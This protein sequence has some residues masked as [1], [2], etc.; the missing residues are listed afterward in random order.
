MSG[1][2]FLLLRRRAARAQAKT[3][4]RMPT[5]LWIAAMLVMTFRIPRPRAAMSGFSIKDASAQRACRHERKK[6]QQSSE[7]R[8]LH[9]RRMRK[10]EASR[11]WLTA[12]PRWAKET[13]HP[14]RNRSP[15]HLSDLQARHRPIVGEE[16]CPS[17]TIRQH[18]QIKKKPIFRKANW[19]PI[20]HA[21]VS[22]TPRSRESDA[23]RRNALG[24]FFPL[25]E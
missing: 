15:H 24:M 2:A 18:P 11:S 22:A 19:R 12:E 4:A 16:H 21:P 9:T 1:V 25:V 14:R 3:H 5:V 13:R 10:M 23:D 17:R 20:G 6:A 8:L 7:A